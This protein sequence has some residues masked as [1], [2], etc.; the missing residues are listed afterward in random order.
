V[1]LS[2]AVTEVLKIKDSLNIPSNISGSFAGDAAVYQDSQN[3]Q[4]WLIL[5]AIAVI[6]VV[7]GM[8]YE[9]WI[10]PITI[11]AGIPSAAVG[12]LLSLEI[13]GLDL[14]FIAM[15]GILLLIG[16]VKKNAI[17][18][19]DFALEAERDRGRTPAEAIMES[20]SLRFRPIMMTTFAAIMGALP[21]ALGLGAGAELRQPMGVAIVGGLIFLQL[22][23]LYITPALYL[24]FD[25]LQHK[26]GLI[27]P[28][29]VDEEAAPVQ[30]VRPHLAPTSKVA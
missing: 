11:L 19:I 27:K 17:M 18:M 20:C 4:L 26:L 29:A 22:I 8:L 28:V 10:H 5:I 9:S 6:Y 7:L 1:P 2:D 12:A 30:P 14:T 24:S 13:V 3:S 23:T 16:I 15:I 21:I 25:W